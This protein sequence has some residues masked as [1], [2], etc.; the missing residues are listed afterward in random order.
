LHSTLL[1]A[2]RTFAALQ[3]HGQPQ[4]EAQAEDEQ[5]QAPQALEVE[6]AQ[7]AHLAEMTP[8]S[9]FPRPDRGLNKG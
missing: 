3:T 7:E 2:D 4:E 5:T 6:S 8:A 1:Q 9:R